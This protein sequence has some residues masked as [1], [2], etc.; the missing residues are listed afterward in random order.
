M[1]FILRRPF[2]F[3]TALK[4]IPKSNPTRTFHQ[5][6]T[7]LTKSTPLKSTPLK[8]TPLKSTPLQSTP[9]KSRPTI[10]KLRITSS[11]EFRSY[12]QPTTL[13]TNTGNLTQ[14][15]LYGAG[16]F[17][18]TILA[19][20]LVFNRE[21]REDGGM[22]PFERSYLND[23]F[24]HTGLG[25]GIIGLTAS[26]LHRNGWSVRLMASNPWLVMGGG[27]LMSIGTMYGCM[28]TPPEKLVTH[29]YPR[30]DG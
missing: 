23:T 11:N 20:N 30:S 18:G 5:T 3:T 7:P 9:L 29:R 13:G 10:L 19:I 16:I 8:S 6:F 26:A 14:R 2:T 4:Q 27:L 1:A 12:S 22:P 25:I 15:L 21:T 28:A 24:L 17:G